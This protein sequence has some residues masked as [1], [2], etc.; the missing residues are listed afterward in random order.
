MVII[1]DKA[2]FQS[3]VRLQLLEAVT[4][5]VE[6][7]YSTIKEENLELS[8]GC[9]YSDLGIGSLRRSAG[10]H[11][12]CV[13]GGRTTHKEYMRSRTEITHS[14]QWVVWDVE[15]KSLQKIHLPR[16]K[17]LWLG[18]RAYWRL[19]PRRIAEILQYTI[20]HNVIQR[21]NISVQSKSSVIFVYPL[22]LFHYFLMA[23]LGT[24]GFMDDSL[25]AP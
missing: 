5:E 16:A 3:F 13:G 21:F 24:I 12:F 19:I 7:T 20:I 22:D 14:H 4:A 23:N 17:A 10:T 6:I 25:A 9:S 2:H 18:R 15:A 8:T 11:V 1:E